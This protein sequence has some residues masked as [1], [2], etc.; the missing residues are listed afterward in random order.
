[1][2]YVEM[3]E[4]DRLG[5]LRGPRE[6]PL[7]AGAGTGTSFAID[8]E[9]TARELGFERP[10]PNSMEAVSNRR[11]A[12][13]F[14]THMATT[15]TTLSRLGADLVLWCSREFGF[16]RLGDAVSTGSSIMPQKRNPDGAELLRGL[17]V[18]VDGTVSRLLELQRGLPLGYF[19][20]LQE[21]KPALFDA[22][23]TLAHMLALAEAMLA[24]AHPQ[25]ER[26]RAAVDDP[27]GFLLATE[28]ADWLVR[29]GLSFREAHEAV[30]ALVRA[31]EQRGVGL[32]DLDGATRAACHPRCTQGLDAVLSVEAALGSRRATGG[33]APERV[34]AELTR[35]QMELGTG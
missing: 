23:D 5:L 11:D 33:T 26:M 28:V 7:G 25:P 22:H 16:L 31:A 35:W 21:D 24:D 29:E 27:A 17:A 4:Q 32:A 18:R 12:V 3:L 20:D 14:A 6:C 2:A 30:G 34:D 8:R 13:L 9:A 15:A 1:L 19:K 10:S